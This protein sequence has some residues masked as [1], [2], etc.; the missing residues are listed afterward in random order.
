MV[1]KISHDQ[2]AELPR[3]GQRRERVPNHKQRIVTERGYVNLEL[4]GEHVA[5]VEHQVLVRDDAAPQSRPAQMD[6]HDVPPLP[7][8]GHPHPRHHHPPRPGHHRASA[9]TASWA[10]SSAPTTQSNA[11]ASAE[12]A[13]AL[14]DSSYFYGHDAH[15]LPSKEGVHETQA[16]QVGDSGDSGGSSGLVNRIVTWVA[17]VASYFLRRVAVSPNGDN[18]Y[19]GSQTETGASGSVVVIDAA[20]NTVKKTITTNFTPSNL[21]VAPTAMSTSRLKIFGERSVVPVVGISNCHL[22]GRY[23]PGR[24]AG[25]R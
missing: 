14:V 1:K 7:R 25:G 2:S 22:P 23:Y 17:Q 13:L 15:Y 11:A 20:T 24:D 19:V 8:S 9:T 4:N 5:Y 12:T 6:R 16:V 3:S 10:D 21:A 18:D